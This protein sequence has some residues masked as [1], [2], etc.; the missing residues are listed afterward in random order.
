METPTVCK[1]SYKRRL[2]RFHGHV[3]QYYGQAMP[4]QLIVIYGP[5]LAGKSTVAR[6]L[7]A[8]LEGKTAVVSLDHILGE[9][10]VTPD[11]DAAAELDMAHMQLRLLVANFMKNHYH[12]VVD[13]AFLYERDGELHSFENE[14]SHLLALMNPLAERALMVRLRA[15]DETLTQRGHATERE[16]EVEEAIRVSAAYQ[17]RFGLRH[18]SIDSDTR[19]PAETADLIRRALDAAVV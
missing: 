17:D 4:R 7:A 6:E 15:S 11:P 19:S 10:I 3:R 16:N 18:I 2:R 5:P 14:I 13:G 1:K 8:G 12:V 9:A